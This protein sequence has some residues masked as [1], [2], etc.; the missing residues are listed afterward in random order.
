MNLFDG[1]AP[2]CVRWNVGN[3]EELDLLDSGGHGCAP[4]FNPRQPERHH[5]NP[6][7]MRQTLF[8]LLRL[9]RASAL[10]SPFKDKME[11]VVG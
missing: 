2:S 11:E 6:H 8:T 5:E 9:L 1:R 3:D 7:V 10:V 4:C